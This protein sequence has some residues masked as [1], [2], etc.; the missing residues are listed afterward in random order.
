MKPLLRYVQSF[1]DKKTGAVFHYF[2]RPGYERVR[3]PGLPG[4]REFML[5]Y[6]DALDQPQI[7][8]GAKRTKVG[9]VN[10]ALVG[11]YDSTMFFGSLAPSTQA[12][13]RGIL[14]RF[15]AE[16]GDKPMAELPP[17][18]IT[19]TLNKLRPSVA[20]NW[21]KAIRHLMQYAVAAD[22]CKVDPTQG[23]KL[24][25]IKT[26][27]IYT[28][29]ET[30][31]A[32]YES[33]WP[34]GTKARLAFVL[35][36]YTAQR[37]SDVIRIG[38]QHIRNGVLQVRQAKT[39]TVLDIPVHQQLQAI[40]DATPGEHLTFLTT[41]TGKPYS[42][43][44]FSEQFRTWCDVAELPK[45]CSGHGLRKAACRRLAEAGCS[46]S[47]IAAISGHATLSEVQRYTKAADQA[48]M[49]R[50]A[51][52]RQAAANDQATSTVKSEKV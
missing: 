12:V 30:D 11:Y 9:T 25:K 22:L 52:A 43:N 48:R 27:G 20:R 50:N 8:I 47:E 51:M 44:D 15:R 41:K 10:A 2:R 34:I 19:L 40:I 3:L 17:K 29:N 24:P 26:S 38:R 32:T 46:A 21:F 42:G 37:R 28:W 39:G 49:A 1:V 4:S 7:A 14:E 31:I 16:H 36:L 35:L 18:F 13:R 5:A 45:E 23:L 33:A 6:Q